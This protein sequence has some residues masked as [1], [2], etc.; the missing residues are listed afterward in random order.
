MRRGLCACLAIVGVLGIPAGAGAATIKVTDT[1]DDFFAAPGGTCSLREAVQAANTDAPF[2]ACP[3]G[4]GA[5]EIVLKSGATYG[6]SIP[7]ADDDNA[8]GDLDIVSPIE[9]APKKSQPATI[10][11]GDTSRVIDVADPGNLH[12]SRLVITGGLT[13]TAEGVEGAGVR[14]F[15]GRLVVTRS[16]ITDNEAAASPGNGNGGAI[17]T[18]FGADSFTKIDRTSITGN[19]AENVG[20]GIIWSGGVMRISKSTVAGN[21]AEHDGG[22]I[23]LGGYVNPDT[24]RFRMTASTISGNDADDAG[25]GIEVGLY[26]AGEPQLAKATNVTISGNRTDGSGGGIHHQA[27]EFH[28]NAATITD[29]TADFDASGDGTGGGVYGFGVIHRNSIVAGNHNP[30]PSTPMEDCANAFSEAH[31][32][33]GAG[34]GCLETGSN[35]AVSDPKLK[36]LGKYGGPTKTHALKPKSKAIGLAGHDAPNRDQRGAKRDAHP[37]AGAYERR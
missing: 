24:D 4:H 9:I 16:R 12:V 32:L 27:G 34:G 29:N 30:N 19:R 35:K 11:A 8:V 7:G 2:G 22:G 36:P 23:Y 31:N 6:L 17:A 5:D 25:G 18:G 20:G 1:A 13:S 37:D 28:L 10:S 15:D 26:V 3:G 21:H 33:V 14:N